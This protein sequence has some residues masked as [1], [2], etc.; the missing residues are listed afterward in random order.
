M[1]YVESL[2]RALHRLMAADPRVHLIGED[3][4]DPYG[5]AFKVAKGLS[6]AFPQ[7]VITTP[8]S[9]AAIVGLGIGMAMRGFRPIVEIMFGDFVTLCMDQ[10]VNHA[11]KF[12][13]VY[14]GQVRVPLTIRLPM[15]GRRGYGA[16]HSQSLEAL[17][18]SVPLIRMVAPS[19]L[20]DPGELLT[21][22]VR[23]EN[24]PVLFIENKLLYARRLL[25]G[26]ACRQE[27]GFAVRA[28]NRAATDYPTLCL[29]MAPDDP[30]EVVVICYGGMTPY[31]MDAAYR[32]FMAE[33]IVVEL[34]VP[35]LIK[36]I[37]VADLI[38]EISR[39]GKVLVAEEG[40]AT[41]GWS[42]EVASVIHE[43]AFDR[44]E[45]PVRRVG[46]RETPIP[47]ARTL[48]EAV[49]PSDHDLE[50]AI[51]ALARRERTADQGWL[52]R[53]REVKAGVYRH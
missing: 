37:P 30:P 7:Q 4:L 14:N 39:C 32:A 24:D 42:A 10:I 35:A 8:I 27:T 11:A 13:W 44:L 20:H 2:N 48:E 53:E 51:Y 22:V 33:E 50:R 43:A 15:G 19:H 17:F 1:R 12:P 49:L 34:V 3:L 52:P 29:S 25:D 36:P 16:T 6:T 40:V 28:V 26:A 31:A 18:M 23:G 41:G 47:S 45:G 46:A 38:P 5:G 9:E 21:S